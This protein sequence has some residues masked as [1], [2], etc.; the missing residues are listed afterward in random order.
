MRKGKK[1]DHMR[2]SSD[3]RAD[4]LTEALRFRHKYAESII[5]NLVSFLKHLVL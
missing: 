2:F 3:F 1:V 4:I 5:D